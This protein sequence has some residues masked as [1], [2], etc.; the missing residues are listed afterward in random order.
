MSLQL[1]LFQIVH[2][3]LK[4]LRLN[5]VVKDLGAVYGAIAVTTLEPFEHILLENA[6]YLVDDQRRWRTFQTLREKIGV[7]PEAILRRNVSDLAGVI[8][9]G[10]MKPEMRAEKV[11]ECARLAMTIGVDRLNAAVRHREPEAK[12]LLR[13][14]PGVGEPYADRILLLAGGEPGLAPDSNALRVLTRLGYIREQKTYAQTYRAAVH[15]A[16]EDLHETE[17][18]VAAHGLLRRHGQEICKRSEPRCELCPL[19]SVCSWYRQAGS[20]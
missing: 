4:M 8:A 1:M 3:R 13:Q 11:L 7:T 20:A 17:D 9:E 19:R 15:A 2:L 18:V 5:R 16:Q 14:F 6:A 12:R 10:G